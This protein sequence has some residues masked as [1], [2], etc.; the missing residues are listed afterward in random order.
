MDGHAVSVGLWCRD[1]V[2]SAITLQA[3]EWNCAFARLRV[4]SA[5]E[6]S[7]GK[8]VGYHPALGYSFC[9]IQIIRPPNQNGLYLPRKGRGKLKLYVR[10]CGFRSRCERGEWRWPR[11]SL[12]GTLGA[13][14]FAWRVLPAHALGEDAQPQRP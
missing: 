14:P 4:R 9:F 13:T 3:L 12:L 1:R 7:L 5:V 2:L 10:E 6:L 8:R 11:L